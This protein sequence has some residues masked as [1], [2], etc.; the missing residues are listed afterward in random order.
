MNALIERAKRHTANDLD[1]RAGEIVKAFYDSDESLTVSLTIKIE[2]AGPDKV[3]LEHGI[4]F[5]ESRV[6]DKD[7]EVF[8]MKQM[9]IFKEE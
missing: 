6:K 1:N 2:H 4:S 7:F 9:Q 3:R 5:V 8:D